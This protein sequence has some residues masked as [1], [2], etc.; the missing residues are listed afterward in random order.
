MGNPRGIPK[1]RLEQRLSHLE[2][3]MIG[4]GL[5]VPRNENLTR[6][7]VKTPELPRFGFTTKKP[8]K[9]GK[10][11]VERLVEGS[12]DP[13]LGGSHRDTPILPPL[14]HDG[15]LHIPTDVKLRPV[16]EARRKERG[17]TRGSTPRP[18]TGARALQTGRNRRGRPPHQVLV[19]TIPAVRKALTSYPAGMGEVTWRKVDRGRVQTQVSPVAPDLS[20]CDA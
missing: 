11:V 5:I 18:T 2:R 4:G 14:G 7:G 16:A 10:L 19:R 20:L 1:D 6:P 15:E 12:Q 9:R 3:K 13:E 17:A 8:R